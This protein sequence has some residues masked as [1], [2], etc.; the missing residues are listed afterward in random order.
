LAHGLG[1]LN[2]KIENPGGNALRSLR[3][4]LG[5]N[6]IAAAAEKEL[7]EKYWLCNPT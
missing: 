7:S 3:L 4:D 6:T 1:K 2:P 5:C